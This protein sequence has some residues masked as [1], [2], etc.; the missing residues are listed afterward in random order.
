MAG[1][2]HRLAGDLAVLCP[3]RIRFFIGKAD[4]DHPLFPGLF[5]GRA[6]SRVQGAAPGGDCDQEGDQGE[7]NGKLQIV[8]P[9]PPF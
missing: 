2:L 4:L 1:D 8:P 5:Q 6:S 7:P 9:I 3:V